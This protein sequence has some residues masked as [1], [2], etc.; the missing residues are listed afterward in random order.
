[1]FVRPHETAPYGGGVGVTKKHKQIMAHT[2]PCRPIAPRYV[3][4][5][6]VP[7]LNMWRWLIT[8]RAIN[9]GVCKYGM[10]GVCKYGMSVTSMLALRKQKPPMEEINATGRV[11]RVLANTCPSNVGM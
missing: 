2:P 4:D 7:Q 8:A 1:M 10:S 11:L 6:M 5:A 9:A 3:A